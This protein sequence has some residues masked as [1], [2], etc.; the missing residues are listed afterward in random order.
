MFVIAKQCHDLG[1]DKLFTKETVARFDIIFPLV[2]L[3]SQTPRKMFTFVKFRYDK[4]Q[5][6]FALW[7]AFLYMS[8]F[9]L[10]WWIF[11]VLLWCM[12]LFHWWIFADKYINESVVSES[13]CDAWENNKSTVK[14]NC[15]IIL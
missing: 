10:Y 11:M 12:I 7:K 9:H 5:K 4:Y 13:S 8:E 14:F 15:I 1:D 6:S 3:Y 2:K